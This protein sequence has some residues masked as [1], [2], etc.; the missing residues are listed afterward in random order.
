VHKEGLIEKKNDNLTEF[1][2]KLAALTPGGDC[3]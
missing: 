1:K 2:I 3:C